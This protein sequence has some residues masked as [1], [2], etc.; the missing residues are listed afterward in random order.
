[1]CKHARRYLSVRVPH[2]AR[3][4]SLTSIK[5][6]RK[7]RTAGA[8]LWLR[9]DNCVTV[10]FHTFDGPTHSPGRYPKYV[11]CVGI[12]QAL[13]SPAPLANTD[14]TYQSIHIAVT[15]FATRN[16][17]AFVYMVLDQHNMVQSSDRIYPIVDCATTYD[18]ASGETKPGTPE[19]YDKQGV[20]GAG[21]L[22]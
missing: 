1:M 18:L 22:T 2:L 15:S 17:Q 8:A 4:M 13:Y 21:R 12:V 6:S 3:L 20:G 11:V 14:P 10:A 16:P 19:T 9:N 5:V 7:Q